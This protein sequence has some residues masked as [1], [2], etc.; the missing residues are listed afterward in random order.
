MLKSG[1]ITGIKIGQIQNSGWILAGAGYDICA[2]LIYLQSHTA[3]C[4]VNS[5]SY[6]CM[7]CYKEVYDDTICKCHLL[8]KR[9][10]TDFPQ[11]SCFHLLQACFIFSRQNIIQPTF[12]CLLTPTPVHYFTTFQF[13]QHYLYNFTRINHLNLPLQ[14][15]K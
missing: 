7:Q 10:L 6:S 12:F 8:G 9:A 14:S 2:T 3:S 11:F 4:T 1:F 15:T 13:N 5:D